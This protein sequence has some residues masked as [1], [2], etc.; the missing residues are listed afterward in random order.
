M[1]P[2]T[3]RQMLKLTGFGAGALGLSAALLMRGGGSAHYR[4]LL[5]G[6]LVP[7]TLGEK[8]LAVLHAFC[9]R[10][11]TADR[12]TAREA[13]VAERIDREL[14]F[15]APRLRR[16]LGAALLL[17]EHGG[18]LH[19]QATRFT[20]LRPDAQDARLTAMS[21]GLDLEQQAFFGL[22]LVCTFFYY[23]DERTW[24]GI[25][26]GGPMTARKPPPADS[27]PFAS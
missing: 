6:G 5:P 14:A 16:D 13:R 11:I 17:V 10:I 21:V 8:E 4:S 23:C 25:H 2:L 9:D 12:P 19:L 7:R 22:R 26:Y 20:R 15:H 18:P 27:N 3:R 1:T 24:P